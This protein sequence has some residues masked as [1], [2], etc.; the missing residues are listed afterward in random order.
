MSARTARAF[1][2][3]GRTRALLS[4]SDSARA[5]HRD[6]DDARAFARAFARDL[7]G[8]HDQLLERIKGGAL[9]LEITINN[10]LARRGAGAP[11]LARDLNIILAEA[12]PY[13]E[14]VPVLVRRRVGALD[15][16]GALDA[17]LGLDTSDRSRAHWEAGQVAPSAARLLACAARLLPAADRARHAEEYRS[18]LWEL[19]QAGA[20]RLGQLGYALRQL[21]STPRTGRALRSLR[22]RGAAS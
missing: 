18:E 11:A 2:R 15:L 8:A 10:A 9:N 1:A 5:L 22:R 16:A 21:R 12:R 4:A 17:A 6:L 19:A 14:L 7:D 13:G 20:G 3:G